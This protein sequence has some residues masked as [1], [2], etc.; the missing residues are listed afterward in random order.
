MP[1]H[2]E[3]VFKALFEELRFMKQQQWTITNYSVLI[4]AAIYAVKNQLPA[5]FP[6]SHSWLRGLAILTAIGGSFLLLRIQSHMAGT[7]CRLDEIH[8]AYFTDDELR[9]VGF[10][11]KEIT[12][13]KFQDYR[14]CRKLAHWWRGLEFTFPLIVVLWVG[15]ILICLAL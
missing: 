4:L 3:T 8:K 14:C 2:V 1:P 5:G 7:R 9:K 13:T 12:K 15:A 11:A 6:H 10:T